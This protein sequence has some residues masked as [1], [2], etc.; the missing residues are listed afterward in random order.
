MKVVVHGKNETALFYDEQ[1]SLKKVL[2]DCTSELPMPC[3]G[4]HKCGKCRV[5]VK[6]SISPISEEEQELLGY[7]YSDERLACFARAIGDCEIFLADYCSKILTDGFRTKY[8]FKPISKGIGAAI[9]VGTTT[10]A[11]YLYNLDNGN[12]LCERAMENPQASFGGD[13]IS[14]IEASLSGNAEKLKNLICST[15]TALIKDMC[16]DANLKYTDCKTAVITGNTAM[17]YLLLCKNVS[18]LSAA[19]FEINCFLGE[20][21]RIDDNGVKIRAYIP[22]TVSAFIGSDIS[23]ALVSAYDK[24]KKENAVLLIDIGTN[25]EMAII[26]DEKIMCCSTA[27]GP[28]FEGS[29]IYMGCMAVEGAIN[30]VWLENDQIYFSTIG[31]LPPCGICGSGLIDTVSVLIRAG[32]IDETGHINNENIRYSEYLTEYDGKPAVK[33]GKSDIIL[34]QND[35][36]AIQLAKA[37]IRAGID[38]LLNACNIMPHNVDRLLLAGGFGSYINVENAAVIGL[39]PFEIAKKSVA[40]GNAAGMG[41]ISILLSKEALEKNS[42]IAKKAVTL[43]LSSSAYF[44]DKYIENM[45]F[46]SEIQSE[47]NE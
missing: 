6:G 7:C 8:S 5:K 28:A 39:I 40:I 33:V 27:A 11:A 41:A 42:Q 14:R 26:K 12:K 45:L 10:V 19:P 24:I 16:R 44:M 2:H 29:G 25:G 36:R 43:D 18:C 9:D 4:N 13:V 38:S 23:C 46:D 30:K 15:I 20:Y 37:A 21:T 3:G 1:V 17:M 34:T 22:R 47:E 31:D 35:V 32:L